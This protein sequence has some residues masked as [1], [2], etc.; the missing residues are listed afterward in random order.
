MI[1]FTPNCTKHFIV[2]HICHI[3]LSMLTQH[4]YSFTDHAFKIPTI[5]LN[6]V[7]RHRRMLLLLNSCTCIL[8]NASIIQTGLPETM[9]TNQ[10]TMYS[11]AYLVFYVLA[12]PTS[13][14]VGWTSIIQC[15][16]VTSWYSNNKSVVFCRLST[17]CRCGSATYPP[18]SENILVSIQM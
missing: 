2:C 11:S 7:C 10:I 9:P 18:N 8:T 4:M 12:V 1:M 15:V 5:R 16:H 13:G 6:N 14:V 17:M 3:Y